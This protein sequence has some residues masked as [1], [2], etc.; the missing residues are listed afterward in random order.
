MNKL[1][2]LFNI[3]Y[4]ENLGLSGLTDESFCLLVSNMVDK[5]NKGTLIVTPTLTDANNLLNI[6]S[7]IRNDVLFFPMDDFL[8]SEAISISPDLMVTR[9]E[10]LNELLNDSKKIVIT[11][12]N[13]YLRYL[14]DKK[15]YQNNILN[16]KVGME[17]A[18][19]KLVNTLY[20]LGYKKETIVTKTG[21]VG[22]RGFVIDIFLVSQ[23]NPIRIEYFGDE[24][25]SIRLFDPE[26]QKSIKEIKEIDIYPYTEFLLYNYDNLIESK[27][28]QKYL[29]KY[30]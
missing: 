25:D 17:Y 14:P 3:K 6:L 10:T 29:P 30:L 1:S 12:I 24:I 4:Q 8:T 16:L 28:K 22:V 27:S 7:S 18:P 5:E 2:E 23:D 21:E 13:G 26:T 9:L 19:N 20:N 15:T 11:D